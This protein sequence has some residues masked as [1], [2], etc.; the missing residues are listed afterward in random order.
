RFAGILDDAQP[1]GPGE[2]LNDVHGSDLAERIDGENGARAAGGGG[3]EMTGINVPGLRV[4]VYEHGA[5]P[6]EH[7]GVGGG[8]EGEGGA[9]DFVIRLDADGADQQVQAA[10]AAGNG[11]GMSNA[12]VI[13]DGAF[14]FVNLRAE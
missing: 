11:D 7:D 8:D 6:L 10:G 5:C 9:D 3:G 12:D 13:G 2:L 14:E 4:D 1:P